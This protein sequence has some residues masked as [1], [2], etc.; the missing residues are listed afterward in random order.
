MAT[1][2]RAC[3]KKRGEARPFLAKIMTADKVYDFGDVYRYDM[4]PLTFESFDDMVQIIEALKSEAEYCI[5]RGDAIQ[6]GPE[7]RRLLR[8]Q[9]D[10]AKATITASEGQSWIML[11]IDKRP[12]EGDLRTN[13]ERL[14]FI[15]SKLPPEFRDTTYY[16]K[17]SS[18]AG[19]DG[20]NYLSCHLW[21]W[22]EE[23]QTCANLH[24]RASRGGDW[25]GMVDPS[26]F[27]PNQIHYTSSPLFD[28]IAD[29]CEGFRSGVVRKAL[30]A[31]P[32]RTWI[33][34]YRPR[35]VMTNRQLEARKPGQQTAELLNEIGLPFYHESIRKVLAN[36]VSVVPR[37]LWDREPLFAEIMQRASVRSYVD[38]DYLERLWDGAVFKF[39]RAE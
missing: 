23:P 39:W 36:Y 38:R 18:K 9:A 13:E 26:V 21:F 25:Y 19:R 15:V 10:G 28:G 24:K 20:W 7:Q 3:A 2:L 1:L 35:P 27:T 34:P 31:A 37:L 22:L 14:E 6:P 17:W 11:D 29:P 5:I 32:V 8:D 33:E 16:Y 30:T 4:T 12:A